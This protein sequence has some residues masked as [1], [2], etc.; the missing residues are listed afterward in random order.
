MIK[1]YLQSNNANIPT[2]PFTSLITLKR[3]IINFTHRLQNYPI[4]KWYE[5]IAVSFIVL[6]SIVVLENKVNL[7]VCMN[8]W[9]EESKYK[10]CNGLENMLLRDKHPTETAI[11]PLKLLALSDS[12]SFKCDI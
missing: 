3:K 6:Y 12:Q 9:S 2:S 10:V 1:K 4:E 7:T 8:N 5:H 11:Q